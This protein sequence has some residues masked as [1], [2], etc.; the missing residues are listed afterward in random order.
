M[1]VTP[2]YIEGLH[3]ALDLARG[4]DPG[5]TLD[6]YRAKLVEFIKAEAAELDA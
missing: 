3:S 1:I 5:T 4:V 2:A 6:E